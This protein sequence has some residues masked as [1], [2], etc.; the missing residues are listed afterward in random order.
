MAYVWARCSPAGAKTAR[1]PAADTVMMS[2]EAAY[3]QLER[4]MQAFRIPKVDA[5]LYDGTSSCKPT[6]HP[7][8]R[9]PSPSTHVPLRAG[10]S[11]VESYLK[12]KE[13]EAQDT[14]HAIAQS[15]RSGFLQASQRLPPTPPANPP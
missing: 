7:H 10:K 5:S 8:P 14:V 11:F 3:A 12:A 6:L 2:N 9:S 1:H 4:E 13:A 15:L